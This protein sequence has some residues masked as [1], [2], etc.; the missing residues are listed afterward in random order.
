VE[1]MIGIA[2]LLVG[3]GVLWVCLALGVYLFTRT[4][5]EGIRIQRMQ[6]ERR[7]QPRDLDPKRPGK[8]RPTREEEAEAGGQPPPPT[9]TVESLPTEP[10]PPAG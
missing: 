2:V 9:T 10:R 6:E 8:T 3:V 7:A 1:T 5:R 4:G